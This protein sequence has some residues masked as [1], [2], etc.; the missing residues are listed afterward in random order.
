MKDNLF[1]AGRATPND[2]EISQETQRLF[3]STYPPYLK[4][5]YA[6]ECFAHRMKYDRF[7]RDLL[8]NYRQL[9]PEAH[10]EVGAT[11]LSRNL[12]LPSKPEKFVHMFDMIAS[13]LVVDKLGQ[14][15]AVA[16]VENPSFGNPE[17]TIAQRDSGVGKT[18]LALELLGIPNFLDRLPAF[19]YDKL[20]TENDF[21]PTI[22]FPQQQMTKLSSLDLSYIGVIDNT[23]LSIP[24][25]GIIP[26]SQWDIARS[27]T[28]AMVVGSGLSYERYHPNIRSYQT[29]CAKKVLLERN[30]FIPKDA[31]IPLTHLITIN[32]IPSPQMSLILQK[33]FGQKPVNFTR[34]ND[35]SWVA[36]EELPQDLGR[37]LAKKMFLSNPLYHVSPFWR[38]DKTHHDETV[39]ALEKHLPDRVACLYIYPGANGYIPGNA[40]SI[41][42]AEAKLVKE[43]LHL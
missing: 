29:N 14:K 21:P 2:V 40:Q 31:Q 24:I 4:G 26:D 18:A 16:I 9:I 36:L 20:I 8:L 17:G 11:L 32:L 43:W 28:R 35:T 30:L 39:M 42:Q 10:D 34:I 41:F 13:I 25:E 23:L 37:D 15:N 5:R 22:L 19:T 3:S 38:V 12:L 33:E 1:Q 27:A 7:Y 6:P